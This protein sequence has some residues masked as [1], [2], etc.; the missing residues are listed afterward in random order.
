[1]NKA[2]FL[3]PILILSAIILFTESCKKQ[4]IYDVSETQSLLDDGISPKELF[5][6]SVPLDSLYG[7]IY[8]DGYIFYLNTDDGTGMVSGMEDL[9]PDAEWGCFETDILD[10]S[11]VPGDPENPEVSPGARVGDGPANTTGIISGCNQAEIAALI[12]RNLGTDWFLPSRGELNL[13]YLRL[14][15]KGFGDFV[16]TWY[17]SSTES[18]VFFAWKQNFWNGNQD[19][20]FKDFEFYVRP[21]RSF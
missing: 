4:E 1:M 5:D 8:K 14:N 12:C 2:N 18:G 10:I 21:V 19:V 16:N 15:E 13:M 20:D 3:Y 9:V 6:G 7:K 17:W 11:N